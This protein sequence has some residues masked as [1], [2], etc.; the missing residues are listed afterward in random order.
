MKKFIATFLSLSLAFSS[1]GIS[2]SASELDTTSEE[3]LE[4]TYSTSDELSSMND[5]VFI[6]ENDD[7]L[8][9]I[10]HY[11]DESSLDEETAIESRIPVFLAPLSVQLIRAGLTQL[12]RQQLMKQF[13]KHALERGGE[14]RITENWVSNSIVY[15]KKF[16]DTN[17]GAKIL[18]NQQTGTSLIMSSDAKTVITMYRQFSPKTVWKPS[19][20]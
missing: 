16:T 6:V 18:W 11:N 14:R 20:F 7:Y 4:N 12:G 5:S 13:T 8:D 19:N 1:L 3:S 15:N 17:T 10:E 9:L 2:A